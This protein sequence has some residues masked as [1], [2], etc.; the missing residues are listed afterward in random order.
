MAKLSEVPELLSH[1]ERVMKSGRV[2]SMCCAVSSTDRQLRA[3]EELL[4]SPPG[5]TAL[6]LLGQAF[7]SSRV[8]ECAMRGPLSAET[9]W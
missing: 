8:G 1:S 9:S 5:R 6:L 3:L 4:S 7:V 2:D